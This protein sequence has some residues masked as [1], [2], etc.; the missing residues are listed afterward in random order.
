MKR[1]V[2]TATIIVWATLT[3]VFAYVYVLIGATWPPVS[4]EYVTRWDYRLGFFALTCFPV[5]LLVLML[6]LLIEWKYLPEKG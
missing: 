1:K 4:D 3:I 6:I 5:L 2:V